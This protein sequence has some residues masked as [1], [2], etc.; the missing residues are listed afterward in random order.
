MSDDSTSDREQSSRLRW[1]CRRGMKELDQLLTS[2]L[3]DGYEA[4]PEADKAAFR[5]LLELSDPELVG[6]LLQRKEPGSE[7][8]ARGIHIL[9]RRN[10]A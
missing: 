9:L 2:Y 8:I 7:I 6:Y 10:N 3:D 5:A 1:Q 4:A